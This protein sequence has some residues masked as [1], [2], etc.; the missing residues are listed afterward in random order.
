MKTETD[1]AQNLQVANTIL[2]QLGGAQFVACTGAT[3]LYGSSN[4]LSFS[5]QGGGGCRNGINRVVVELMPSD[6]YAVKFYRFRRGSKLVTVEEH[7]DVY[8]DA[9]Q[10]VFERATGLYTSL[11]ARR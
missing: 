5:L 11:Y 9:L 10:D 8:F 1:Q 4:S 2:E 7:D 6:T 3:N